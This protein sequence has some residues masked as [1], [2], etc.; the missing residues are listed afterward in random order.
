MLV[1]TELGFIGLIA[2][3]IFYISIIITLFDCLNFEKNDIFKTFISSFRII[4]GR[5]FV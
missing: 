3:V 2:I 5:L 1:I 4:P